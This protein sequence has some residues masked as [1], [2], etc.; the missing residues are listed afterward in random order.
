MHRCTEA[1]NPQVKFQPDVLPGTN[2]VTRHQPTTVWVGAVAYEHS[3]LVPWQGIVRPWPM[4]PG[5]MLDA[6]H[7]EAVRAMEPEVVIYGSGARLVF[8]PAA[9]LRALVDARIGVET[10]DTAAACRT[11]NVLVAEGRRA[12][13]ALRLPAL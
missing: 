4:E 7:F 10:M 2:V 6:A 3:I 8:P 13:A 12:V 11:F 9:V 1:E 5:A